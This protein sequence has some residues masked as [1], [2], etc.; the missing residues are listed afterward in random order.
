MSAAPP[1]GIYVPAV[2][3][4]D[5]NEDLHVPHIQAHVLRLAR[6]GVTGI[7]V[8]GSNGEAQHLSPDERKKAIKITRETLD[9]NGFQNVLV[10]AGTGAQSTR[11][12]I[13]LCVDAKEAGASHALVLTPSVWPKSMTQEN[14]IQFHTQV[15]DAS[16]IPTMIYNFPTVTAGLDLDSELIGKLATHPNIVGTK[17]SCGNIGKIHRLT[18]RF[19]SSEF[20]VYAGRSD[21]CLF[22]LLGG[23]AGAIAALVNLFPRLHVRMYKLFE[24]GNIKE[25]MKS[26]AGL[27]HGDWAISKLGG[28]AGV[29]AFIAANFDYGNPSVR[30][31][32]Q[33]VNIEPYHPG[34]PS[35]AGGTGPCCCGT[36]EEILLCLLKLEQA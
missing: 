6:G 22:G 20:A 31:P 23:S 34:S 7:L 15:A 28:V 13:R 32:L 12:T 3:F 8:Q 10:I 17:L 1:P 4:F 27:S 11:E 25:A 24:E 35:Q 26:Q 19:S 5:E 14:I 29:K 2:I 18:S 9:K 33:V 21:A 30:R 16:P 36:P